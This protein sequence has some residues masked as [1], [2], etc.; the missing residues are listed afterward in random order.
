MEGSLSLEKE[1]LRLLSY[2]YHKYDVTDQGED[3]DKHMSRN[4]Y[5]RYYIIQ[6]KQDVDQ[7]DVK[8]PY[9][10]NLSPEL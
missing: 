4:Y 5:R 6:D 7:M 9:V 3:A 1:C 8:I 2:L 10:Y